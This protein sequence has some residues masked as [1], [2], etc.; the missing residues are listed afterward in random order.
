[1]ILTLESAQTHAPH[2]KRRRAA[3]CPRAFH[4]DR[5]HHLE[6]AWQRQ[7]VTLLVHTC[8]SCGACLLK[9]Q[10]RFSCKASTGL[11]KSMP[12]TADY[13]WELTPSCLLEYAYVVPTI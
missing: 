2:A 9:K 13:F 5:K 4:I 7:Q 8:P 3:T 1:M 10:R 6:L 11:L 12:S